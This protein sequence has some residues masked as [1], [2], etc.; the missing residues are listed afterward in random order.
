MGELATDRTQRKRFRG[1]MFELVHQYTWAEL[2]ILARLCV[3]LLERSSKAP[4]RCVYGGAR[5]K[6]VAFQYSVAMDQK[7]E[8]G[9]LWP[10]ISYS[11][12]ASVAPEGILNTSA[13][14]DISKTCIFTL[15]KWDFYLLLLK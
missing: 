12:G 7:H 10:A 3:N 14:S 5:V 2:G 15:V 4:G 9:D 8:E 1:W 11:D 13:A 6:G